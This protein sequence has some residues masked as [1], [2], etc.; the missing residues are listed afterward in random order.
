MA[1]RRSPRIVSVVLAAAAGLVALGT[2]GA[3][4]L[5]SRN[6]MLRSSPTVAALAAGA[7]PAFAAE[8]AAKEAAEAGSKIELGGGFA[9]NLDI[10]ETGIVNI[11][12]LVGG[13]LYLLAPLLSESMAAR[14]KEIQSDIDDA[15][16]KYNEA[17]S[18]LAEAEKAKAQA[19]QVVAEINSSIDKEVAA[20]EATLKKTAKETAEMQEKTADSRLQAMKDSAEERFEGFINKEAVAQGVSELKRLEKAKVS[21]FTDAM[22]NTI[23]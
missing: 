15:I 4:F 19:D 20:F 14:E 12:I 21:K 18:R 23:N 11:A 17:T 22:L 1:A 10:P 16:A 5:P 9:I 3:A 2:M 13:L 7:A 8:E 6:P